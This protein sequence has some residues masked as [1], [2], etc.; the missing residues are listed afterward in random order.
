MKAT[1]LGL[2]GFN[3]DTLS[4]GNQ[5]KANAAIN[6][7]DSAIQKALDQQTTIGAVES[8]RVHSGKPD[9][10]KRERNCS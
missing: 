4:V 6:V 1:A 8:R 3:G 9:H 5:E 2:Q 10:C 7:I